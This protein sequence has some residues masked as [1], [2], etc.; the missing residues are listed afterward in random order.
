MLLVPSSIRLMPLLIDYA[1]INCTKSISNVTKRWLMKCRMLFRINGNE[2]TSYQ[3]TRSTSH[4]S[5]AHTQRQTGKKER[6]T[7]GVYVDTS[8]DLDSN[9][10]GQQWTDYMRCFSHN[11]CAVSNLWGVWNKA[12][13]GRI[14]H[15]ETMLRTLVYWEWFFSIDLVA[16]LDRP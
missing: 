9:A 16:F 7:H 3:Y 13:I 11:F 4:W 1:S 5:L 8:K 12:V 10:S 15:S 14:R 6:E 2:P